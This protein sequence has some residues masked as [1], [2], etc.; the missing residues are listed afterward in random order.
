MAPELFEEEYNELVDIYS[1]GVCMLELV[2]Y[3]YQY[4]ECKNQAQIYKKGIKL[5]DVNKVRYL[6]VKQFIEK[7]LAPAS[8]R[9]SVVQLLKEPFLLA[10]D[11]KDLMCDPLQLTDFTPKSMI[12]L[13]SDSH[14]MDLDPNYKLLSAGTCAHSMIGT[15]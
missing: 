13:K 10:K 2:T 9:S 1:F 5:A 6:E 11:P 7:C 4:G 3:E 12:S 14:F 15:P 8:Q